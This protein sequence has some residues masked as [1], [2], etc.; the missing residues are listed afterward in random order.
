MQLTNQILDL[1]KQRHKPQGPMKTTIITASISE[2]SFD[3]AI[4]HVSRSLQALRFL[5]LLLLLSL[6]L[7]FYQLVIGVQVVTDRHTGYFD[8]IEKPN[9]R[10]CY[11]QPNKGKL[12]Q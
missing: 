7:L 10:N 11:Q 4:A 12:R 2:S 8:C 9:T 3:Y 6:L 5:L 1:L